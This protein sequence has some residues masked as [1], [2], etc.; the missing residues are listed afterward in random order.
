MTE[1]RFVVCRTVD[2]CKLLPELD[3]EEYNDDDYTYSLLDMVQRRVVHRD[4]GE[5]E[6]NTLK[7]NNSWVCPLLNELAG[8][9]DELA[10]LRKMYDRSEA[11]TDEM[12]C[13]ID[14]LQA[15]IRRMKGSK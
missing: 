13:Q 5:P 6:D 4:G 7:R 9:E 14:I 3:D 10:D 8:A 15:T 1:K 2:V 11:D 12:L